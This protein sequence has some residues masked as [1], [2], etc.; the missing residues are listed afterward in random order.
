MF[1]CRRGVALRDYSTTELL[2]FFLGNFDAFEELDLGRILLLTVF[3]AQEE[4]FG[5]IILPHCMHFLCSVEL[6]L[7]DLIGEAGLLLPVFLVVQVTRF[8]LPPVYFFLGDDI[9]WAF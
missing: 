9:V 3:L 1:Y 4:H 8:S 6:P 7:C 2:R 5:R